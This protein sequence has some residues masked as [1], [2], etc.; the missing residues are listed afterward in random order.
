[1]AWL[2]RTHEWFEQQPNPNNCSVRLLR[3]TQDCGYV[4]G[5]FPPE[6]NAGQAPG[7]PTT[8]GDKEEDLVSAVSQAGSSLAE[9][10]EGSVSRASLQKRL[11]ELLAEAQHIK[12]LIATLK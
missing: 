4:F 8:H 2:A 9:A 6:R 5:G 3:G 7:A 10:S 11:D 12:Q 1:M